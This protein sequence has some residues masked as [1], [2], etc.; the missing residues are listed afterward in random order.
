VGLCRRYGGVH[1]SRGLASGSSL[2]E[3]AIGPSRTVSDIYARFP[4]GHEHDVTAS[5][6]LSFASE[7]SNVARVADDGTITSVGSGQA[8]IVITYTL[9]DKQKQ[10]SLPITVATI[11]Q[12]L[13]LSSATL[14]FGDIPSSTS[15]AA[16]RVTITNHTPNEIHIF[17]LEPRG[18]FS[19]GPENCSETILPPGNS[20][21]IS[22]A[23]SPIRPG[24]I[25]SN[26]FVPTSFGPILSIGLFGNG[27]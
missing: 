3:I 21:V 23:L 11:Q 15:S 5:T 8:H 26:I 1:S 17:K 9:G 2:R 14:D 16:L 7:N 19:V 25:H 4:N 6:Y 22:V 20:C 12:G 13:D 24:H 18:G 27:T 10:I